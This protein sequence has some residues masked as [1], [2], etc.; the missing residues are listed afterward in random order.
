[1]QP[2]LA[3]VLLTVAQWKRSQWKFAA[4]LD[5]SDPNVLVLWASDGQNV[6]TAVFSVS[7]LEPLPVSQR[8]TLAIAKLAN[9]FQ[10]V[11][12]MSHAEVLRR[13]YNLN[14]VPTARSLTRS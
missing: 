9:L 11:E 6:G 13:S 14:T 3:E 10:S 7:E 5:A 2:T 8:I 1:M 12:D 4:E